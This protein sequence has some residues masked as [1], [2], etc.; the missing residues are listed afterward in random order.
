M[1]F[2]REDTDILDEDDVEVMEPSDY[3]VIIFN[4]NVSTFELV[5]YILMNI[6]HR[7]KEEAEELTMKIHQEGEAE[8]GRYTYDI[9]LTK[10]IISEDQARKVG[11][12]LKLELRK[13]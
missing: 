10:K 9:A 13:V 7:S 11:Y 12:P 1:G 2:E 3:A 4:D 5:I 8:V 6:F